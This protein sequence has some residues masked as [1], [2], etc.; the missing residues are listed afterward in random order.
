MAVYVDNMFDTALYKTQWRQSSFYWPRACHMWA[1]TLAELIEMADR[2]GLKRS[3][4]QNN[5]KLPHYDLTESKRA[6]A[7]KCGA[8]ESSLRAHYR[9]QR[10]GKR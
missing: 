7:V 10:G 6:L 5:K 1:D 3:W 8:E 2:I 4:L 9:K